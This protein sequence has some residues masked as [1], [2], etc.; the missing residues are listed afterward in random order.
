MRELVP[1]VLES[2]IDEFRKILL[3]CISFTNRINIDFVDW[4]R[5]ENKTIGV[6]LVIETLDGLQCELIIDYDLM[7]DDPEYTIKRLLEQKFTRNISLNVDTKRELD[8]LVTLANST[9]AIKAGLSL[10]PENEV[11]DYSKYFENLSLI[12]ILTIKPGKQGNPFLP[13]VLKKSTEIKDLGFNG[14]VSVDGGVNLGTID[15]VVKYPFDSITVGSGIVK[16]SN[17]VRAYITLKEK[18]HSY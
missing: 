7:M 6:D 10:N 17:P 5:T 12:N 1:I 2:N 3:D 4:S 9:G 15:E 16:Q 13:E 14:I 8:D 11:S 18:I